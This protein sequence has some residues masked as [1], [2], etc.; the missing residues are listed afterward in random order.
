MTFTPITFT[1]LCQVVFGT[2]GVLL[3]LL[4]VGVALSEPVEMARR[5][6]RHLR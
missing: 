6:T 2:A 5:R 3:L 1:Y 4:L